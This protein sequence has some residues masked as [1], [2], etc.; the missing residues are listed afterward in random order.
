MS[1]SK[2]LF[3]LEILKYKCYWEKDW[4]IKQ[5][6]FWLH[7]QFIMQDISHFIFTMK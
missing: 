6:N 7:K 2:K 5:C 4:E 3:I 1:S